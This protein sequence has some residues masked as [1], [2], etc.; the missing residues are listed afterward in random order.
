M[1]TGPRFA[2]GTVKIRISGPSDAVVALKIALKALAEGRDPRDTLG[3]LEVGLSG[4]TD[5]AVAS[6]SKRPDWATAVW[7]VTVK[8]APAVAGTK[9]STDA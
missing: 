8:T 5:H 2:A 3:H 6:R 4:Y 9:E 7:V 1:S